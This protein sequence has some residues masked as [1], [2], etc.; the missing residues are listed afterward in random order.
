MKKAILRLVVS[1][2]LIAPPALAA[3][4]FAADM[5][6]KAPP[7]PAATQYNWTGF[8]AGI[9]GG[10][11]WGQSQFFDADPTDSS[12][13]APITKKFDVSGGIL[14]AT[15]GY[16]WQSNYWGVGVEGDFS[17]LTKQGISKSIPPFNTMG[18]N[19][20]HEHWLG[21]G[22]LRL[23]VVPVDRRLFYVTGGFAAAGVEAIFHGNSARDGNI[24]QTQTRWGWT[25]GGGFETALFQN[26]SFKLE[27]LYIGLQDKSY[28]PQITILPD[29]M[30][31]RRNVT[32]N[33]N[34]LRVGLNYR[35]N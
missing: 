11:A 13:G 15:A 12:V 23:G 5:A 16:N 4:A 26:W 20:T 17:W 6:V 25:A 35:F 34:I 7:S 9:A 31:V 18:S 24:A 33:D 19:A 21:T 8:Y 22:R 14:G 32:L 2:F 3:D 10:L 1:G 30:L 29:F 27:Y 28:F